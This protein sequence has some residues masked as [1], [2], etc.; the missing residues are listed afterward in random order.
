[1]IDIEA[2][3]DYEKFIMWLNSDP[4]H[5]RSLYNRVKRKHTKEHPR[6]RNECEDCRSIKLV[7]AYIARLTR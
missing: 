7:D 5:V 4:K 2:T 1:M 6:L 3:D